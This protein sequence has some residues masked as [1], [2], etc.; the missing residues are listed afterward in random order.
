MQHLWRR[1]GEDRHLRFGSCKRSP[2]KLVSDINNFKGHVTR[3]LQTF[4]ECQDWQIEHVAIA[5][6]LD[7][8]QRRILARHNLIPQDLVD[9]TDGL[10]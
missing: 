10:Q 2:G 5:P 8:E 9:L 4:R 6:Q 7:A 1:A 3:F